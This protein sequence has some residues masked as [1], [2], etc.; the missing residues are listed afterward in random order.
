MKIVS[1]GSTDIQALV[2][3]SL[4]SSVLLLHMAGK[5]SMDHHSLP[6]PEIHIP[7]YSAFHA[8]S[9]IYPSTEC[10]HVGKGVVV[11]VGQSLLLLFVSMY[12]G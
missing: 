7:N 4:A 2:T 10:D 11:G 5:V 12:L 8:W 9:F 3:L 1:I 6:L